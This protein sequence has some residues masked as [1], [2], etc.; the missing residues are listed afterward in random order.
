LFLAPAV[1]G[2]DLGVITCAYC[3]LLLILVLSGIRDAL[4]END[5]DK[6]S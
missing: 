4:D 3:L 1:F 6:S 2:N 5:R